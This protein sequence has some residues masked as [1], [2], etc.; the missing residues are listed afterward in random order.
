MAEVQPTPTKSLSPLQC[1]RAKLAE[2]RATGTLVGDPIEAND[3]GRVFSQ[4]RDSKKTL[5]VSSAKANIGR[6][7]F[8]DEPQ[9]GEEAQIQ[10]GPTMKSMR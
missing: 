5:R 1:L 3:A 9:Q 6:A 4:D 10:Q 2:L 7:A 8:R